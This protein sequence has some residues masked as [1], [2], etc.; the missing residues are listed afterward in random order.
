[1]KFKRIILIVIDSVGCGALPDASSYGDA[2]TDTLKSIAKSVGS[3]SLPNM[4]SLG[5]GALTEIP[6][7]APPAVPQGYYARAALLSAGKDTITGH[8]EMMGLHVTEPFITFTET[9]FPEDLLDEIRRK[10]GRGILGNK[11]ASGTEIIDELGEEHC[12][13]GKLIVY[14]SADSVLQIAAHEEVIPPEELWEICR[15]CRE[16]TME[17]RWRVGRII[18]RPFV[19]KG[20]GAYI[21][22]A[23]RHDF[24]LAPIR[25]SVLDHLHEAG[26]PVTAVGKIN[27]IFNGCGITESIPAESNRHGMETVNNLMERDASGLLFVNLVDFDSRFGHRRDPE[28]YAGELKTFD[29]ELGTLMKKVRKEELLIVTA[30]HGNDPTHTG[31][32]HTREYVPLLLFNPLFTEGRRFEDRRTLGDVG[33][34]VATNFGVATT[35]IGEDFL[36]DIL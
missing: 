31:S 36:H 24:A 9:G 1:M 22:T 18:A 25:M 11:S 6:G 12:R 35:E 21:R 28:G 10:T 20:S 27:D 3:L 19:G 29:R 5:L 8:W 14:T 4:G 2:G 32:D 30:D 15:I 13:S 34:S 17:S 7:T 16:I 33:A 26:I 23:N